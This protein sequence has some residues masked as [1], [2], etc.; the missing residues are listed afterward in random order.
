MYR[1]I[2]IALEG[3]ETDETVLAH[4]Q[5]LSAQSKAEVTLLWVITIALES[6]V[7]PVEATSALA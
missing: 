5:T 7:K 6:W 1:K 4:V 3:K 2:L